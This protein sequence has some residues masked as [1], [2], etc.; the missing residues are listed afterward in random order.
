[1]QEEARIEAGAHGRRSSAGGEGNRGHAD[2]RN[3]QL[4]LE[5]Q[6]QAVGADAE[7]QVRD[8]CGQL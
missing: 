3:L 7:E 5:G 1:M 4:G 2:E 8:S 6:A